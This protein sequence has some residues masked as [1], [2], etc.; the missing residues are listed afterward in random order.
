MSRELRAKS[1][2]LTA[3]SSQLLLKIQK[4]TATHCRSSIISE[5]FSLSEEIALVIAPVVYFAFHEF[6]GSQDSWVWHFFVGP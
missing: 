4:T 3:H 5:T 1:S 6:L 2:W